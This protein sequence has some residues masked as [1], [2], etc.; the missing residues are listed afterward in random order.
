MAMLLGYSMVGYRD[1]ENGIR[2]LLPSKGR[3]LSEA[4]GIDGDE[5]GKVMQAIREWCKEVI[6]DEDIVGYNPYIK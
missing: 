4:F 1:H 6:I 5:I 2:K 3:I